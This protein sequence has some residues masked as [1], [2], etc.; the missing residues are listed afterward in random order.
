MKVLI[1]L[2]LF[3]GIWA[4]LTVGL[5]WWLYDVYVMRSHTPE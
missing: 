2:L 5:T 4:P 3:W 1:A